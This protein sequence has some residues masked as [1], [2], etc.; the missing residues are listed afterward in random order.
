MPI[1]PV[2]R[3]GAPVDSFPARVAFPVSLAG[4]HPRLRVGIRDFTFEACSGFTHVTARP[5]AQPPKAAFVTEASTRP[6][7]QPSRSSATRPFRLLSGW[8]LP[9][10]VIRAFRGTQRNPGAAAQPASQIPDFAPLNP[11]YGAAGKRGTGLAW[12]RHLTPRIRWKARPLQPIHPSPPKI[13]RRAA[14]R[15]VAA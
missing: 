15:A 8:I 3:T 9:P 4:R 13:P 6:V 2:D 7:A 14:P 1:T 10:L 5:V 11:G 12:R